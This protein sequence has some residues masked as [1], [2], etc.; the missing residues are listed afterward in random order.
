[1]TGN[2]RDG[3]AE[4]IIAVAGVPSATQGGQGGR[5]RD[6]LDGASNTIMIGELA[7]RNQLIR[8]SVAVASTN[9]SAIYQSKFGGGAWADPTNGTWQLTGRLYDGTSDRG[10][11]AINCSNERAEAGHGDVSRWAAGLYSYHVGGA[12]VL[13]A[14]GAVRF[15][16]ENLS[17]AV[18]VA[19]I[20]RASGETVGEF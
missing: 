18:F 8:N 7:G 9:T 12:H 2:D 14:D 11:C 20:S 5:I 13:L 15:L 6:M 4:G 16:S 19:L 3:W 17:G 10:P 1:M